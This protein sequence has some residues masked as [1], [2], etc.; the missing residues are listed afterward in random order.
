MVSKEQFD[1]IHADFIES[2]EFLDLAHHNGRGIDF[3]CHHNAY[4][5][6]GFLQRHGLECLIWTCGYYQ[7]RDPEKRIRHSWIK[8]DRD[9]R[10][11]AILE[12]DPLQLHEAGGYESDL[13]PSGR[14]PESSVIFGGI[15][16]I[17]DPDM[18]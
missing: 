9:G 16:S 14:I 13:M 4:L 1:A 12:L 7:C 18:V 17:V 5:V 15:A 2:Q 10:T 6:A 3:V 8:L 11:V